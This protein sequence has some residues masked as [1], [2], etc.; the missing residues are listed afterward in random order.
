MNDAFMDCTKRLD[1]DVGVVRISQ[2]AL[3][4]AVWIA[5]VYV[6]VLATPILIACGIWS[7]SLMLSLMLAG[8][9]LLLCYVL[10]KY[11]A[12][13]TSRQKIFIEAD[14]LWIQT[15]DGA[16]KSYAWKE[17]SEL[18]AVAMFGPHHATIPAIFMYRLP[19]L[20][21]QFGISEE[22]ELCNIFNTP[23]RDIVGGLESTLRKI[24]KR[25]ESNIY[26]A[27]VISKSF[28]TLEAHVLN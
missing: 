9:G 5:S 27:R 7:C 4:C 6:F 3:F 8:V 22:V 19:C 26:L 2:T 16:T 10:N 25:S 20:R 15:I 1:C 11:L 14:R 24:Y 21:A 28:P 12:F 23:E 13:Q 17:L 18:K